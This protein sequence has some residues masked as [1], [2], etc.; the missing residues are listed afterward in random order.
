MQAP[1]RWTAK[2]KKEILDQ[3][4]AGEISEADIRGPPY[5]ISADEL[6]E[7]RDRIATHGFTGL[8]LY[9]FR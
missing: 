3:I 9:S 5:E 7:W 1:Q 2:R 4:D 8:R 6:A